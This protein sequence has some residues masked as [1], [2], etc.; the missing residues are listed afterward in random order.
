MTPK[1]PSAIPGG[2]A[3]LAFP[4]LLLLSGL[5]Q[6]T[7]DGVLVLGR[8]SDDPRRHYEQL[9]PLLDYVVPRMADVGITEGR[10]LMARDPQ[11]MMSYLRRGKVDWVTE[12]PGTGLLLADRVG[13]RPLLLTERSGSREYRSVIFTH[14]DSG[15]TELSQLRGHTIAFQSPSSTSA[16]LVP[17]MVLR[18]RGLP[19]NLMISPL[20]DADP[21]SVG[22]VFANTDA[23]L[24]TWVHKRLVDA[25]GFS[26]QDFE[27]LLRVSDAFRRDLVVIHTTGPVPRAMELVNA[28][29]RPE[30]AARLKEVL[31]GAA[32]DPQAREALRQFF[33]TT[34]FY[35]ADA[36]TR[37]ALEEL[38]RGARDV[39]E[40][41]E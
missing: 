19:M 21:G 15:I 35:E 26:D 11:Q 3:R 30:V 39:R 8:I 10:V 31:L 36:E 16:Y 23:N 24:G 18:E 13:A 27:S 7:E 12:T 25:G 40:A 5:A 38:R 22:Y 17:A 9:K 34:G 20:D 41:L 32:D 28:D 29:M 1:S 6:A 4:L 37:A 2:L 33:R 14:R